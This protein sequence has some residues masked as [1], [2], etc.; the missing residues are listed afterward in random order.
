MQY[1]AYVVLY[2]VNSKRAIVAE[3]PLMYGID[4][5]ITGPELMLISVLELVLL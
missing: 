3:V 1:N 4:A 2:V 5:V